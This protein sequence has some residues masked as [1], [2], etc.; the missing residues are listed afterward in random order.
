MNFLKKI[1][2]RRRKKRLLVIG[3]DGVP[4]E[5]AYDDPGLH[6]PHLRNLFAS[7]ATYRM[8]TIIPPITVPAWACMVTGKTPGELG[9]YGFRNRRAGAYQLD[10]VTSLDIHHSAIWDV[11]GRKGKNVCVIG[12]PPSYPPRP[13][14]GIMLG[15][16]LT[17]DSDSPYAYPPEIKSEIEANVGP[18]Q[19]DVR[20]FRTD[21]KENLL[22]QIYDLTEYRFRLYRYFIRRSEWDFLMFV[23]MGPDRMHHGFWK[24]Y[25]PHHIRYQKDHPLNSAMHR[26][27]AELDKKIGE[28]LEDVD[29]TTTVVVV[30]DHGAKRMDGGICINE[31]LMKHGYLHLTRA[32]DGIERVDDIGIDWSR[33]IAWGEGGYYGRIFLNIK[34]REKN[35]VLSPKDAEKVKREIIEGLEEL[36]DENGQPI[37]TK[38]Y[39]PEDIYPEAAGTPPDLIAIFGDLHWRSI[40]S[41][42]YGSFWT[43]ENDTGPDDANH[44]WHGI[45]SVTADTSNRGDA[46][47]ISI[48]DIHKILLSHLE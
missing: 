41:V 25:D 22:Q 36:G 39:K 14:N 7:S 24:F 18:F 45:F 16:F 10:I 47:E 23:D 2:S 1:L 6:L 26:Y 38:V 30:S 11:L 46:G 44:S 8:K 37:G 27:Y 43:R 19:F 40:G 5:M 13:V 12:V 42:G 9:I 29:D 28:L 34:G 4:P 21:D 32:P 20:K 48:L 17:P 15:C 31:W 33:T 3:L 35:G